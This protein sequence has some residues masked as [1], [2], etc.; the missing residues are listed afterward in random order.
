[1]SP[2]SFAKLEADV[3]RSYIK[4][5]LDDENPWVHFS[6]YCHCMQFGMFFVDCINRV[7]YSGEEQTMKTRLPPVN[8]KG[9]LFNFAVFKNIPY[10]LFCLSVFIAFLG[11]YTGELPPLMPIQTS[12][13][14]TNFG[15]SRL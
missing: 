12:S 3:Q 15:K 11:M 5:S 4:F 8:V 7:N 2:S 10:T 1:V 14:T 6:L 9:G 13:E